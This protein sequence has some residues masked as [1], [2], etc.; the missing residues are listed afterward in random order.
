MNFELN[1]IG[2][3]SNERDM[4]YNYKER[5]RMLLAVKKDD[6]YFI[7]V[8][9]DS[10]YQNQG[11]EYHKSYSEWRSDPDNSYGFQFIHDKREHSYIDG[12]GFVPHKAEVAERI[13]MLKCCSLLG[14]VMLIMLV[15]DQILYQVLKLIAPDTTGAIVYF[16]QKNGGTSR[17]DLVTTLIIGVFMLAKFIVPALI[18][19]IVTKIPGRVIFARSSGNKKFLGTALII[20]MVIIVIGRIGQ[21]LIAWFFSFVNIDGLYA[22]IIFSKEPDVAIASFL[23]FTILIPIAQEVLFRGVILQTFR[24]FGDY[25]AIIVSSVLSALCYYDITYF[26]FV[27]CCSAVLGLFTVRTGSLKTPIFMSICS[28]ITNFVLSYVELY[29]IP[30]S[31]LIEVL[32]CTVILGISIVLYSKLLN[33]GEWSFNIEND[34]SNMS[35]SKRL[36]AFISTNSIAIWFAAVLVAVIMFMRFL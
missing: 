25:F 34:A 20:M 29:D 4:C 10:T 5:G 26:G 28:H 12:E 7:D 33:V 23:L 8:V 21:F 16:S 22:V 13:S 2:S 35:M 9:K 3:L 30:S 31:E 19:K 6:E 18:F 14:T 17:Y 15:I 27:I 24:Q 36:K 32:I 1:R 11:D